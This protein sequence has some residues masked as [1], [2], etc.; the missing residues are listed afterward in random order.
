MLEFNWKP[1]KTFPMPLHLQIEGY[2]KEKISLNEW[3]IGTKLPSQR[4][5]A[6]LF[7]VNRSTIIAAMDELATEGII[8]GN[9]GGGTKII[10]NTWN[11]MNQNYNWNGYITSGTINQ[12]I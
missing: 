3:F 1:D 10:N 8:Q 9:S 11:L 7:E 4:T 12:T 5:L 6:E 2:I